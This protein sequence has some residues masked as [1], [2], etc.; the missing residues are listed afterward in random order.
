MNKR[1]RQVSLSKY[2]VVGVL[3]TAVHYATL[4]GAVEFL[5]VPAVEAAAVGA[6]YGA[7]VAYWG[8][9]RFTFASAKAHRLALPAFLTVA[10]VSA[11]LSALLVWL[12]SVRLGVHYIAA[13]AVAT[14]TTLGVG[15]LL[16]KR[17]TF[18]A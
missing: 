8:N 7:A 2:S 12:L 4:V 13:Q 6:L 18:A 9:R 15:Y 17:W 14:A 10:A 3:A 11:G 16:N 1:E 5:S